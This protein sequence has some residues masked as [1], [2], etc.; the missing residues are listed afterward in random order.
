MS[1]PTGSMT[2]GDFVRYCEAPHNPRWRRGQTYFNALWEL[3]PDLSEQIRGKYELDPF[4]R[5]ELLPA[6]LEFVRANWDTPPTQPE[7]GEK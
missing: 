1:E 6:F 5:D 2:F 4:H 7:P 3:R